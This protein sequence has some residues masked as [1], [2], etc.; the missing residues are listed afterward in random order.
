MSATN[1]TS[2]LGLNS[3]IATDFPNRADFNEDNAIVDR[4]F[5]EHSN[6][7]TVHVNETERDTWNNLY[8]IGYYYG[9]GQATQTVQTDCPFE[10]SFGII[11]AMTTAPTVTDFTKGIKYNYFAIIT[12]RGETLG[13]SIS[14]TELVVK[15]SAL[16]IVSNEYAS[17]NARGYTYQYILFR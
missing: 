10:P 3:W 9:N 2:F 11:S 8:Y 12:P 15:Q 14:G 5:A 13:S 7:K 17:L 6:D 1:K 16:P 4:A